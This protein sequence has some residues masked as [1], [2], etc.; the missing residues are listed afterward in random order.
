MTDI[1]DSILSYLDS[2]PVF[3]KTNERNRFQ[4]GD[5]AALQHLA[6]KGYVVIGNVL[7]K[8]EVNVATSMFWD[9]AENC[10]SGNEKIDRND[11]S[12]WN[13]WPGWKDTGVIPENG[14][15]QSELLWYIRQN[16]NVINVFQEIW[17]TDELVCSFDGCGAFRPTHNNKKWKTN[18]G[19]WHID[20]NPVL[21]PDRA[22]IQGF[23][24]L[25]D[26][27]SSTGGFICKPEGLKHFNDVEASTDQ[28]NFI[29][30]KSDKETHK[31]ILDFESK[32]IECQAGDMI[33]W[34]SRLPHCNTPAL[35]EPKR[36]IGNEL[37][38]LVTYVCMTPK[39]LATAET[40][41]LRKQ[42]FRHGVTTS[43]WP[44]VFSRAS[45]KVDIPI[46][47]ALTE[48]MK[49]LIGY[50]ENEKEVEFVLNKD[51]LSPGYFA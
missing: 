22:C 49:K 32:L 37:L 21:L 9:Y 35:S 20:Q 42:A 6:K 10:Y 11:T 33:L 25:T 4:V 2:L 7:T 19:W 50:E 34:D 30:L 29:I 44:H 26:Q 3:G 18:T 13:N 51:F 31:H 15:G 36:T 48:K 27:N 40:L 39:S 8:E 1:C 28:G 14:I 23:V 16:D 45:T 12:T 46:E 5:P 41:S 17:E 47:M 24:S 38:R 43:H